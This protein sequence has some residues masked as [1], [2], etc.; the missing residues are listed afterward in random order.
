MPEV[1]QLLEFKT[2]IIYIVTHFVVNALSGCVCVC[3]CVCVCECVLRNFENCILTVDGS[4]N[5]TFP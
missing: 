3:V 4:K 2:N 5:M 1:S